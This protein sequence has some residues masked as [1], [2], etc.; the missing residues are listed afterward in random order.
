MFGISNTASSNGYTIVIFLV[1]I[2]GS[3]GKFKQK[4]GANFFTI[5][6]VVNAVVS[7]IQPVYVKHRKLT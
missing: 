5:I 7:V 4:I 1:I 6:I 2:N 3:I